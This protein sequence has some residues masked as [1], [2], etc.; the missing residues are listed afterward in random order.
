MKRRM[1]G[2]LA[3]LSLLLFAAVVWTWV[4]SFDEDVA[5]L[6]WKWSGDRYAVRSHWG[7]LMFVG[8]PGAGVGADAE[9]ESLGARM[10]NQDLAWTS[11][12]HDY[13]QGEVHP[14]TATWEM[15]ERVAD[16]TDDAIV[17]A[18][19][20][21]CL[22]G[23][24]DRRRF[25]ACHVILLLEAEDRWRARWVDEAKQPWREASAVGDRKILFIV[26]DETGAGPDPSRVRALGD[27]WDAVLYEARG[28]IFYGWVALGAL[29]LP[30]AWAARPRREP[31][32]VARWV[33]N[34]MV[35][36]SA[37]ALVV[38]TAGWV[39][40]HRAEDQ[41]AFAPR[42]VRAEGFYQPLRWQ[43]WLQSRE[44]KLR[45]L[46]TQFPDNPGWTFRNPTPRAP[47]RYEARVTADVARATAQGFAPKGERYVKWPG[48]LEY[49]AMPPQVMERQMQAPVRIAMP[50][51]TP[52]QV[53]RQAA[54][55]GLP[56]GTVMGNVTVR[57]CYG[58]RSVAV[59]WWVLVAV[60]AILP[61]AWTW[62]HWRWMGRERRARQNLCRKCGYDLRASIGRCPECGEAIAAAV[63]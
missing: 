49:C 14:G 10:S 6:A 25:A 17:A 61:P 35:T 32:T 2:I 55:T 34:G 51:L 52:A 7:R 37:I 9:L 59:S 3:A 38:A 5:L 43:G 58:M 8:P 27:R 1:F 42:A 23:V 24:E 63:A 39:R 21:V 47:A 26:A 22:R 11:L 13:V 20:R 50:L 62:R 56:P 48:L 41:W 19:L 29:A 28:T 30:V 12:G 44:G 45:W 54:A 31:R 40:S 18:V 53:A 46:E 33:F 4:R 57:A 60:S 36:A 16:A 15:D